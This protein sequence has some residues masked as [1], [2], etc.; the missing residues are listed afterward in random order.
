MG[1]MPGLSGSSGVALLIPFT[2][3]L[4]PITS[5]ALLL[6]LY[7]AAEYGGSITA[8]TLATP[9]TPAAAMTAVDG[10][11]LTQ[12]GQ[13]GR[14]L[15]IS[16]YSSTF[17]GLFSTVILILF[18]IPLARVAI[19]FGPV[20]YFSLGIFGLSIIAS[21][22]GGAWLKGILSALLGLLIKTIG[23][24]PLTGNERF[25]FGWPLLWDGV[26]FL[27]MMLGLFAIS[28][29]FFV[30]ESEAKSRIK[31][32]TF[33]SESIG[34]K[35]FWGLWKCLLR[36]SVIGTAVGI[37]PGAGASIGSII[38]YNE[39]KRSSK[40]PEEFGKGSI[41]GVMACESANN[42]TVGGAL[43]PLLM[44]GVPGSATTAI[45]I[46]ALMLQNISPGPLLFSRRPD[47]IYGIFTILFLANIVMLAAGLLG[48]RFWLRVVRIPPSILAPLIFGIS[49]IGAYSLTG[50]IGDVTIMLLAG[51]LGYVM[52][53]FHYPL[54]PMVIALVLGYM[55]EI[56]L[57]R[58]LILSDGSFLIFLTSPISAGFLLLTVLSLAWAIFR[59]IRSPRPAH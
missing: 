26:S 19:E 52:R 59:D 29:V 34:W 17:G 41:E 40:N 1:A 35:E 5:L 31:D 58:A 3:S 8:I 51:M 4:S 24:D 13:T 45:L 54:L 39:A 23:T 55:V 6:S 38:S 36:S 42:A 21:L 7:T 56:S 20:E 46:G 14:A 48:I 44:L 11:P 25:T 16:L 2:Y 28:E 10:Y 30:I 15:S 37:V 12:K 43:V 50:S 18:S 9:G 22:S 49:F 57:R 47:I 33:T 27:P 53:K 32:A